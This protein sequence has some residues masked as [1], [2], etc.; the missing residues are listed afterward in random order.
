MISLCNELALKWKQHFKDYLICVDTSEENSNY[1][2][3]ED[4]EKK[5]ILFCACKHREGSDIKNLDCSVF[6]DKVEKRNPKTFVQCV[7]RVLRKN[8]N[9][10]YGLVLDLKASNCLKVCDRMNHYLNCGSNFPWNYYY[11]NEFINNKNITVNH[12]RLCKPKQSKKKT[13]TI[14]Y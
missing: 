5:A 2:K 13:K 1:D 4:A 6:L 10:P 9:K 14:H 8:K 11:E 12:L 7:G 3:F